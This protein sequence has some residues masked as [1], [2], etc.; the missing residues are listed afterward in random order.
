MLAMFVENVKSLSYK[1]KELEGLDL[2]WTGIRIDDYETKFLIEL[3][4]RNSDTIE[5]K[6]RKMWITQNPSG[7]NKKYISK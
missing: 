6:F 1:G 5:L 3:K 4:L 7:I 2:K